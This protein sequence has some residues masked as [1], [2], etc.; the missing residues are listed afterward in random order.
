MSKISQASARRFKMRAAALEEAEE[1]RRNRWAS[2]YPGGVHIGSVS[3]AD[4]QRHAG[5]IE[6]ARLLGHAV[7]ATISSDGVAVNFY[8]LP[9]AEAKP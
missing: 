1:Q 4:M 3:F 7:V 8:A 9:L 2:S 6:A 5:R